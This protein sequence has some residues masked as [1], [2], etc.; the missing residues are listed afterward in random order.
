MRIRPLIALAFVLLAVPATAQFSDSYNFIKAVRDLDVV[1]ARKLLDAPGATV[2]NTR[3]PATGEAPIH[4]VVRR[5]DL[6]WLG[7]LLQ[8]NADANARDR[9]GSTP[10]LLAATSRFID[11]VR[12]LIAVQARVDLKNNAG[13][14]PLIKAVQAHDADTVKLL[15]DAGANPDL[16]DNAAGLSARQY[17]ARDVR[18]GPIAKLL[19]EAKPRSAAPVQ[20]PSL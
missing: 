6:P 15:L 19:A 10:L 20:G 2:I 8:A 11:G 1:K 3:D 12:I 13:E 16:A 18:G 7:F 4:I 5:R 14:T 9:D 17:A